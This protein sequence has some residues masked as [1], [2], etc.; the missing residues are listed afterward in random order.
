MNTIEN[1]LHSLVIIQEL[2]VKTDDALENKKEEIKIAGGGV[3]A[4]G[5]LVK[6]HDE[7]MKKNKQEL[8]EKVKEGKLSQEFV[9]AAMNIMSNSHEMIKK[10]LKDKTA[11]YNIKKGEAM[12][13]DSSVKMLKTTHEMLSNNKKS[14]EEMKRIELEQKQ[15]EKEFLEKQK[16]E[17]LQ[18]RPE[19]QDNEAP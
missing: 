6:A 16:E 12:A 19:E 14:I 5:E 9:R 4:V 10:F 3:I 13:F 2:G 18:R 17:L 1:L 15:R 11:T 7:F 8:E